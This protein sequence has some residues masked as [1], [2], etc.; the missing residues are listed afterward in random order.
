M[1]AGSEAA[2]VLS[3]VLH[4]AVGPDSVEQARAQSQLLF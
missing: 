4:P 3:A 1:T 2:S